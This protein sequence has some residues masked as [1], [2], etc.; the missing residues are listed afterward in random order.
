MAVAL[1][2]DRASAARPD[3]AAAPIATRAVPATIFMMVP[4]RMPSAPVIA[5][6][7]TGSISSE[8]A[9]N[10]FGV[11]LTHRAFIWILPTIP[12]P[13]VLDIVLRST[14]SFVLSLAAT[15]F[16]Q[17]IPLLKTSVA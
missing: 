14:A 11:Y 1:P 4:G 6:S 13:A 3:F 15:A 9:K 2:P 12:G 10:T 7:I 16:L 5:E 8:V 17:R